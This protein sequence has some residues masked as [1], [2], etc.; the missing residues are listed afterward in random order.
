MGK[1]QILSSLG[2]KYETMQLHCEEVY[3]QGC[4]RRA[5]L[6]ALLNL[7][8]IF[9]RVMGLRSIKEH[10]LDNDV[11]T[12]LILNPVLNIFLNISLY[13]LQSILQT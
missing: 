3:V 11:D 1:D 12:F 2:N 5:K 9:M 4:A 6:Y 8:K 13:D 10:R 7:S